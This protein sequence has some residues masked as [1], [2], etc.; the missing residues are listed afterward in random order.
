MLAVT[1]VEGVVVVK[2]VTVTDDLVVTMGVTVVVDVTMTVVVSTAFELIHEQNIETELL[3]GC[4]VVRR[5]EV[6][7]TVLDAAADEE[8]LR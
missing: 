6:V 2:R 3:R 8:V 5:A 4:V 7:L 1:V